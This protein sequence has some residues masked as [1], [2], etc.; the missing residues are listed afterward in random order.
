M[1]VPVGVVGGTDFNLDFG[2]FTEE[3]RRTGTGYNFGTPR[4]AG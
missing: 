1:E 2:M 4:R 3:E